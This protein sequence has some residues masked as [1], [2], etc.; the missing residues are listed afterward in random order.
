MKYVCL[1]PKSRNQCCVMLVFATAAYQGRLRLQNLPLAKF[2]FKFPFIHGDPSLKIP[3]FRL[4]LRY[5]GFEDS[6][7]LKNVDRPIRVRKVSI[8]SIYAENHFFIALGK[9]V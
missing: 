3:N 4:I 7:W 5:D 9:D 1:I 8:S 6:N 2:A